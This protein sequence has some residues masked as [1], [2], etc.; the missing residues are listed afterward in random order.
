MKILQCFC[1]ARRTQSFYSKCLEEVSTE[2]EK[3][4]LW[5]LVEEATKSSNDIKEFCKS[6]NIKNGN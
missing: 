3:E 1:E 6:I 2:E 4:F 5:R